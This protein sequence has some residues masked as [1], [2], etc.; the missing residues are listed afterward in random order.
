MTTTAQPRNAGMRERVGEITRSLTF[1]YVIVALILCSGVLVG[2]ETVASLDERFGAWFDL[3]QHLILAAFVVEAALKMFAVAPRIG[4]YFRDWWNVFDFAIIV[5]SLIPAVGV[6]AIVA[7]MARLLRVLRL[8]SVIPELRLLVA[9]L[10]RSIP[11]MLHIVAL[12]GALSYIYAIV[13][14]Q[15]FSEHDPTHWH[16]LGTSLLSLF[17]VVTLEDWTDIMYKAM[18]LHPL[19]SLYFV[20]FVVLCTFMVLNLFTALVVGNLD[21]MRAAGVVRGGGEEDEPAAEAV[22]PVVED[23]ADAEAL[24]QA[25]DGAYESLRRLERQLER[26]AGERERPE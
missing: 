8:I 14:Y 10:V 19:L 25:I 11:G 23:P 18:E 4:R 16:N 1:E 20:S 13:G 3:G 22:A 15:L 9:T 24:R 17:R 2:L 6:W 26:V 21:Q 5:L 7:R 12:L